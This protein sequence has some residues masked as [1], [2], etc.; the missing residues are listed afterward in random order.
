MR[1]LRKVRG[2]CMQTF[3]FLAS[4]EVFD[5]SIKEA[6]TMFLIPARM[7]LIIFSPLII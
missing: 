1:P 4:Q 5:V 6:K 7:T 2:S 3:K